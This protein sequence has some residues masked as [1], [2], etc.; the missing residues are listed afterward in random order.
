[1]QSE[2]I[3]YQTIFENIVGK[4]KE[5]TKLFRIV[6]KIAPTNATV[7]LQG[8]SGTGKEI[9][10]RLIHRLSYRNQS[11]FI[12]INCSVLN[13][14]LLEN[15]L[16]G[17]IK[18]AFTGATYYKKGL[19]Q[20]ADTG[21]LFLDEVADIP[22]LVQTKLLRVLQE[23]EFKPLGSNATIKSDVRVIAATNSNLYELVSKKKFREDLYY[24][25]AVIPIFIPPLRERIDDIPELVKY[26]I[27][28]YN[29]ENKKSIKGIDPLAMETLK[30]YYWQGNVR[31]LENTIERAVALANHSIVTLED[32]FGTN[33]ENTLQA[34][35]TLKCTISHNTYQ[36]IKKALEYTS[37]NRSE[38]AKILGISR[39]TL[40]Y[41]LRKFPTID[42]SV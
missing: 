19:F 18:G 9:I 41:H 23:K 17:H 26:F 36:A 8:E 32:L 35:T 5:M 21:T 4:S 16:F 24:R 25:L 1:M 37:G 30:K 14:N 13:E 40:Y 20:E 29:R 31:E 3:Q 10:A 2:Q 11:P 34:T 27:L 15:E 7:L 33:Y 22:A 12:A 38:A 39:A 28:K 6:G 42:E